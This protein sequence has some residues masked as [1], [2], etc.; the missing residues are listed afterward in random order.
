MVVA[1]MLVVEGV[2]VR[3]LSVILMMRQREIVNGEM[4][5]GWGD[6]CCCCK[7]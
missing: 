1:L 4:L 2:V 3:M 7:G 5:D 6:C